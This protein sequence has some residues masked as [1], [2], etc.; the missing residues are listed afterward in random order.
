MRDCFYIHP[1]ASSAQVDSLVKSHISFPLVGVGYNLLK[2]YLIHI[3]PHPFPSKE[4]GVKAF[5]EFF[6]VKE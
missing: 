4:R 1:K 3:D 2:Y 5:Y 6:K